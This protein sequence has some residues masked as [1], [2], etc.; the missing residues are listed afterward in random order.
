MNSTLACRLAKGLL[1]S[2]LGTAPAWAAR[3]IAGVRFDDQLALGEQTLVLNGAGLR[4][5]MIVK[6]YA[7]GLYV[8]H[9]DVT[10]AGLLDQAGAKSVRIVLLRDVVAEQLNEALVHGIVANVTPAE[11]AGLHAR[12]EELEAAIMRGGNVHKGNVVQIDYRPESGTRLSMGDKVLTVRDIPGDDFYRAL[13]KIWLGDK[14]SDT[15]LRR[16]LLGSP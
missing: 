7:V 9:K 2:A 3:E 8:G 16:D 15:S 6:V 5:K 10:A 4:V 11:A 14:P 1:L 13:L 12:L